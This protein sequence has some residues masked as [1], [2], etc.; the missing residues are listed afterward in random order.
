MEG[1]GAALTPFVY[2]HRENQSRHEIRGVTPSNNSKGVR[3]L[4]TN[5]FIPGLA[6]HVSYIAS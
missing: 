6:V 1:K 2:S 5:S 3:R 4:R